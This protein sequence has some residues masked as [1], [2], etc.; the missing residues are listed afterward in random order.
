M[1]SLKVAGHRAA[2]SKVRVVIDLN[3]KDRFLF[4][5]AAGGTIV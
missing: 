5:E 1:L 4:L 3:R 2:A